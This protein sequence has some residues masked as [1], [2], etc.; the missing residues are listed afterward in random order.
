MVLIFSNSKD[1][2]TDRVIEW[3]MAFGSEYRR[4]NSE[5]LTDDSIPFFCDPPEGRVSLRGMRGL[6]DKR[7]PVRVCW[8]RRWNRFRIPSPVNGDP[9]LQQLRL[10]T[11]REAE[12]ISRF[13]FDRFRDLPWLSDPESATSEEK[14]LT[15][16]SAKKNGLRVPKSIITNRREEVL[17]TFGEGDKV[18]IKPITDPH[19]FLDRENQSFHR[20]FAEP[21]DRSTLKELPHSFFPSFFQERIERSHEVRSFYL[22]G[23]FYST[24]L[25]TPPSEQRIDIKL[26]NG[27]QEDMTKMNRTRIPGE[28]KKALIELMKELGLN[29]GSIDLLVRPDGE[30]FF[31]EVNPVGQFIGYGE[32]VNYALDRKIAEWLHQKDRTHADQKELVP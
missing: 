11:W 1:P 18:V 5:D 13:L 22:D 8:Y 2:T 26:A 25:F 23:S 19:G 30:H 12:A 3:L 9:M 15:L 7:T 27:M 17:R 32:Q 14:I 20:I 31:L 24:A 21:L 10:E 6:D 16:R 4:I 29:S 28:V